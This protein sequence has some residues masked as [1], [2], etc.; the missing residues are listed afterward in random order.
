MAL[1]FLPPS[2][3]PAVALSAASHPLTAKAEGRGC[4][5]NTRNVPGALKAPPRKLVL[6]V[7]R[8]RSGLML[9]YPGRAPDT[10]QVFYVVRNK[11]APRCTAVDG[12]RVQAPFFLHLFSRKRPR[13]IGAARQMVA[14]E[15]NC[16][17]FGTQPLRLGQLR[18]RPVPQPR[19]HAA[20]NDRLIIGCLAK[21]V[22]PIARPE[23]LD[24]TPC[25]HWE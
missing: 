20:P 8:L 10:C 19:N 17:F 5:P 9:F 21:E 12:E 22:C 7:L 16:V 1:R 11:R 6:S 13:K 2:A 4:T 15:G 18:L 23:R 25:I 3:T 24:Q 14:Q